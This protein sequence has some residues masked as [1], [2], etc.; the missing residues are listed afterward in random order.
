ML[1]EQA[2]VDTFRLFPWCGYQR[3]PCP[4][5]P[6]LQNHILRGLFTCWTLVPPGLML[7][8]P[9]TLRA[10]VKSVME[11]PCPGCHSIYKLFSMF[12]GLA[13]SLRLLRF[14]MTS[15]QRIPWSPA[16][17]I[18]RA[19]TASDVIEN[20]VVEIAWY[21]CLGWHGAGMLF[22]LHIACDC[23]CL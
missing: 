19:L 8:Q 23:C 18:P 16:A 3:L 4:I 11:Y 22:Q 7:S 15:K 9:P 14:T 6:N 21:F 17:F 1:F 20:G 2:L 10:S 13:M 5:A 12:D